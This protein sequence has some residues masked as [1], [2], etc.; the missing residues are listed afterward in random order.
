VDVGFFEGF[1]MPML[2][3]RN[4]GREDLEGTRRAVIVNAAF[5]QQVLG[6]GSALGREL[7]YPTDGED[8]PRFE[9][10]GVAPDLGM[11]PLNPRGGAGVYHP[12]APGEIDAPWLA[13]HIGPNPLFFAPTLYDLAT[14]VEPAA[15]IEYPMTL[16]DVAPGD[17]RLVVAAMVAS[18]VLAAILLGLAASGIYA[19]MAFTVARRTRE[20][21]IRTALGARRGDIAASIGRRAALQIGLGVVLGMPIAGRIYFLTQEDPAAT[22]AAVVAAV[23]P[24]VGA[25]VLLG[26]VACS[27]PLLRA[28]R[29]LPTEA[30]RA[31]V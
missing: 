3:G 27:G 8:A 18:A 20:I 22:G 5:V 2:A 1:G 9:I 28:I 4:F 25:M 15:I 21:G 12:V 24:A 16:G 7:H 19:I 13:V 17:L 6:G 23:L 14:E 29:V 31:E 10:V 11:D 26:L 30:I